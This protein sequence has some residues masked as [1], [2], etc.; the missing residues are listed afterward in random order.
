[1]KVLV[2]HH[3]YDGQTER[4]ARRMGEVIERAGHRVT[5]Q[6]FGSEDLLDATRG[7]DAVV[8]GAAIRYGHHDRKLE[9]AVRRHA[10]AMAALPNAFFSVCLSAGGPGRNEGAARGYVEAFCRNTGWRPRESASFAGAL[11]YSRYGFFMKIMMKLIVGHAGGDTDTS[12]DYQYTDWPAVE[13]FA[14]AFAKSL[15]A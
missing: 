5:V 6:G 2:L 12:R 11:Q 9:S 13:R 3:S 8:V 7:H 4:I 10:Q 14:I 1:V 15:P